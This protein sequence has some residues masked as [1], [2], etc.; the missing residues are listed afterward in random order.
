MITIKIKTVN[1][2]VET[3]TTE[4]FTVGEKKKWYPEILDIRVFIETR[5]VL[6]KKRHLQWFYKKFLYKP[7]QIELKPDGAESGEA[8]QA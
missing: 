7:S 3:F 4:K 1:G 2:D 8:A 5:C 6:H